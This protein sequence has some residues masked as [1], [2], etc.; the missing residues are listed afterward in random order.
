MREDGDEVEVATTGLEA[1][2]LAREREYDLVVTDYQMGTAKGRDVYLALKAKQASPRVL[3]ITGDMLNA[4][5]VRF[6]DD[7]KVKYLPKPLLMPEL[8][9]VARKMLGGN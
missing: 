9:Q 6:F 3:F 1:L 5:V 7:T 8:R 4:E 2:R